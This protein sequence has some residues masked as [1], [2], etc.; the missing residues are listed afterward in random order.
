MSQ[1]ICTPLGL[2]DHNNF[3][4][5]EEVL[6]SLNYEMFPDKKVLLVKKGNYLVVSTDYYSKIKKVRR[7]TQKEYP[8]KALPWVVDTIENGFLKKPAE[9]G[10]SNFERSKHKEFD[11]ETIGINVMMHCCAENLPGLNIWN[12]NREDYIAKISPQE[13]DIPLYMLKEGLLDELKKI[14]AKYSIQ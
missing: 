2:I 10:F 9:G 13:W 8:L 1:N 6:L 11:G 3:K 14:A 4:N 7:Y 5:D 12:G